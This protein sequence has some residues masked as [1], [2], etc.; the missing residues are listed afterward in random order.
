[1]NKLCST[2]IG[3]LLVISLISGCWLFELNANGEEGVVLCLEPNVMNVEP[4]QIFTLNVSISNVQSLYKWTMGLSWN[5]SVIELEPALTSA[6]SEGP[7][8][9]SFGRT[10]FTVLP[11]TAGSGC[12]SYISC[13][14]TQP[15]SAS[16]SGVLLT[17]RFKT[18]TKGETKITISGSVLYDYCKQKISHTCKDGYVSSTS[19]FH[20]IAVSLEAPDRVILGESTLLN[21]TIFNEGEVDE[22]DVTLKILINDSVW[23]SENLTLLMKAGSE[24]RTYSWA[25]QSK[26][27]YNITACV[28]PKQY[29]I[30]LANNY[31]VRIVNVVELIHDVA[32]SLEVPNK[33]VKGEPVNINV[34]VR[35]V[36]AYNEANVVLSISINGAT[37]NETTIDSLTSGFMET[38]TYVWA[39]D[40]EG[41]YV[42]AV[43]VNPVNGE[44]IIDNNRASKTVSVVASSTEQKQ[45]LIVSD[46]DSQYY[47]KGTS[48][49]EFEGA[50]QSA[51]YTYDIWEESIRGRP[52]LS[53]LLNYE[54]VVWTTGDHAVPAIDTVDMRTLVEYSCNGGALLVEGETVA[55]EGNSEF[56]SKVLHVDFNGYLPGSSVIGMSVSKQNHPITKNVEN[57]TWNSTPYYQVD[58]VTPSFGA[59]SVMRFY[60]EDYYFNVSASRSYL[61][62]VT[63][64]DGVDAGSVIYFAFALSNIQESKEIL[65]KNCVDWLL[66]KDISTV[67]SKLVNAP[68]GYVYFIY[69]DP[70][71][72]T[73]NETFGMVA[74]ATVYGSCKSPQKQGFVTNKDWIAYGKINSTEIN[75]AIIA[76]FGNPEYHEV[77]RNYED[78]GLT[79]IRFYENETHYMLLHDGKTVISVSK[80]DVE[81]GLD[82]AFV[83]YTFSDGKNEFLVMY[84]F[85]WKS[86]WDSGKFFV[87]VMSKN[88]MCYAQNV[89]IA[90]WDCVAN[91]Y[92][93]IR[94]SG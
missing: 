31:D 88:F 53:E 16:G 45:I 83:I 26:G 74:G 72:I 32:V 52:Y 60:G 73:V 22:T 70:S 76:L 51:G 64:F 1:M 85:S 69:A 25:P 56:R 58:C 81:K 23:Q 37:V 57:I 41:A 55:F 10:Y 67:G 12:L 6:V 93:E 35:N 9:K 13:E 4:G 28:T 46:D 15:T 68:E 77:I 49:S 8:L 43:S 84:G 91:C 24:K 42:I 30:N 65:V 14:F 61:S 38:V 19:I 3:F 11:Y 29:E 86:M 21:V 33:V 79:P 71:Y 18:I 34:T 44:A 75:G 5:S 82:D 90:K 47:H 62:A 27:Y 66:R 80:E 59:Y 89:Y 2:M 48:L 63:V 92:F 54:L 7:F 50:L 20:D 78:E 87:D 36:G 40:V 94:I 17:V 39:P